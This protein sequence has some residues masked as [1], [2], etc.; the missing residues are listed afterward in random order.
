MLININNP[1]K[2]RKTAK[3]AAFVYELRYVLM[4][5]VLKD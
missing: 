1:K 5:D 4:E 3:G 2:I